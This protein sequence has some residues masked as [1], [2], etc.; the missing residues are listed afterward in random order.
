MKKKLNE[1]KLILSAISENESVARS[2]VSLFVS[3]LDP[4]LDELADIRCA[5]SE[6]VTNCIVHG[7]R[8]KDSGSIYITARYYSDRSVQL[9]VADRGVGIDDVTQAMQPLFTTGGEERSGMG[10]S[11]MQSFTDRLKVTSVPG[12]G[13]RVVML[14]KFK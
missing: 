2:T 14:K 1:I 8:G 12:K 5:V 13:T 3:R 11:I 4:S 10:F 7:Y 6:A 9:T